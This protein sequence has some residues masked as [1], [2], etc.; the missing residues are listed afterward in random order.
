MVRLRFAPS[1]TGY[2]HIGGLRTALFC[3]LYARKNG[4]KFIFRLEDTDQKR[5]FEGAEN[6]LATTLEW[7]GIEIDEGPQYGGK[8]GPYRQSERLDIYGKYTSLLLEE[9]NAYRCF[10]TSERLEKLRNEQRKKGNNP[11]YDGFCRNISKLEASRRVES[12]EDYVVRMKIPEVPETMVLNDLIRGI[13]SIDTSQSEDQVIVKS[14]GF[15][16]YHLAVVIDDYLMKITHVVRGEEWIP[17]FPKHLLLYRYFGWDPPQFA[18]LPL[19]L[20]PDRTKL[21]KRQGDVAVEDFR[22]N[23]Y[24]P[25]SL[26]NFVAM[27]GWS[28][29]EDKELFTLPE[30]IREFS[31]ER[32]N[33]SGAIFDQEKLKWMNQQYIQKLE[34]DDLQDRLNPF[35]KKSRYSGKDPKILRKIIKILQPRLVTLSEIE[36]RLPLFFENNPKASNPKVLKVLGEEKSKQV[37]TNFIKQAESVEKLTKNNLVELMKKVQ[38]ETKIKGKNLWIPLRY[39]ITLDT[40]GPD[41]NLIVEF[42]GKEKCLHLARSALKF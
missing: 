20:N 36:D 23:G 1:P 39:A 29:R 31:L 25:E 16:T 34:L 22:N 37:L 5:I 7:S 9:G 8:H 3:W 19:I 32:V 12:G 14:D 2:L 28:P 13:V 27:L 41:L 33:K 11:R 15:P 26:L 24:L 4:G 21:S 35:I 18:H 6:K 30:L 10:C 38:N 40:E 42:F 17:S